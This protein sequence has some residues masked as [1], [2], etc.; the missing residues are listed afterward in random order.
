MPSARRIGSRG[1]AMIELKLKVQLLRDDE[2]A[3][4]PGKA[5]LLEAIQATGSIAA[6]ARAMGMSYRRAWL[7]VE[8][9]NRCF[10]KP[11]VE[12]GRGG[13]ERGGTSLTPLGRSA[14]ARYRSLQRAVEKAAAPHL[15]KLAGDVAP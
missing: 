4:G 1:N 13:S 11:L 3:F 7:L 10:R 8:V 12:T 2:I 15:R 6:A 14:L 5:D 9:M